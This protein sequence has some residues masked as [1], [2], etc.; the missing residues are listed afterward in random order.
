MTKVP[1]SES[2]QDL[3]LWLVLMK[4]FKA[5]EREALRSIAGTGVCFSDFQVLELLL[6]KGPLPVNMIGAKIGLTSG[7]ITTAIDRLAARSLVTREDDP[8]D[9]RTRVV[10]LTGAGQTLIESAFERHS[11]DMQRIF[12]TLSQDEKASLTALLKKLGQAA[13]GC[14]AKETDATQLIEN[15]K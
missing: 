13:A 15:T 9:R 10:H 2:G 11:S 3:H 8:N 12:D 5:V 1:V 6:H 4:A 7:S 14:H